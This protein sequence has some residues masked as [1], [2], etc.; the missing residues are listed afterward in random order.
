LN[1]AAHVVEGIDVPGT[2]ETILAALLKG[3]KASINLKVIV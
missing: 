3:R 2:R 1:L